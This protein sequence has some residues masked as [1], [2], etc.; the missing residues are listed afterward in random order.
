LNIPNAAERYAMSAVAHADDTTFDH[1]VLESDVPVV[2]DFWAS[3]CGPCRVVAPEL[4][5][6]AAEHGDTLK[7]V[8]VDVDAAP[9][10]AG[11][12]GV[13]GIPTIALFRDGRQVAVTVG[14][15]PRRAIEDDLG[16]VRPAAS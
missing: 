5:A 1:E 4:E 11:R 3:W 12:Y 13:Q 6:L 7:V 15:K 10:V 16:L 14:A 2:V 9:G 8:K